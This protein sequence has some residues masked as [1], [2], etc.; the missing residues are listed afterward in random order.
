MNEKLRIA[1]NAL[2][3][4]KAMELAAIRVGDLTSVADYFVLATATSNTHVKTLAD[5]V[6]FKLS[7]AG[8]QPHH[9]EGRATGWILIDYCDIVVH[10]FSREARQFYNLDKMWFDGE[11]VDISK[12]L[13]SSTEE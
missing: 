5:E 8:V 6:E 4:K 11:A 13:E 1:L 2:N 12:Y 10:V 3:E 7:E 9:V